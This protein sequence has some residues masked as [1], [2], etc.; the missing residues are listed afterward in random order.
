MEF[1]SFKQRRL[2]PRHQVHEKNNCF[3]VSSKQ[4]FLLLQKNNCF[5]VHDQLDVLSRIVVGLK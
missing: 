4:D 5:T 3:S 2:H 1:I